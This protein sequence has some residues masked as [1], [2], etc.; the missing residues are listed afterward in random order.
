MK[1]LYYKLWQD[2][3]RVK[4]NDTPATNAMIMISVFNGINIITLMIL[5]DYFL[6]IQKYTVSRSEIYTFSTILGLS[7]MGIN[8]F[9]LY[10]K[11]D[12][13]T[14]K[15]KGESKTMS[16]IGFFLVYFYMIGSFFLVYFVSKKFPL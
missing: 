9:L 2:F 12:A 3:R 8:Y 4:T 5:A 15:Y 6:Q 1:Y 7:V 14:E 16:R 11:R 10:K 13:I